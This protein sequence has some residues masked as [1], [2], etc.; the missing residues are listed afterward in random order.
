[1]ADYYRIPLSCA[2]NQNMR[3]NIPVDGGNLQ[4]SFQVRYNTIAGYWVLSISDKDDNMLLDSIP[5]VTAENILEQYSY[6]RLGSAYVCNLGNQD[7]DYPDDTT[8][9]SDFIFAW[10]DTL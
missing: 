6:L 3:C 5:L 8:L 7:L 4:L 1:M 2:P 9:G 10:G